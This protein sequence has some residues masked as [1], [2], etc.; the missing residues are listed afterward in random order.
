MQSANGRNIVD[1][2]LVEWVCTPCRML[3]RVVESCCAKF[4][5]T[6]VITEA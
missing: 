1:V 6:S 5:T 3:V 4:E 2:T